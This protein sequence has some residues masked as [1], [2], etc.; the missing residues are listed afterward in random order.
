MA[1]LF[2]TSI[3]ASVSVLNLLTATTTFTPNFLAFSMCFCRLQHPFNTKSTFS[4]MYSFWSGLPADTGGPPPCIF[5]ART[6]ATMTAALGFKPLYRHLML[7]NFSIPMSA[8]KPASVTQNP[9]G[10]ISLRAIWSATT[11]L[12]PV[13]I[14]A[15]GPACT[16]TGVLSTVCI[17]VG[18]MASFINTV[19]APPQPRSS[20]VTGSPCREYPTTI[21]PS[22]SRRS[23][24]SFAN[25][26]TAI[27]SDA[28][29][30]S[31]PV[32]RSCWIRSPSFSFFDFT[33][34]FGPCPTVI[35]RKCR[36]HVSKTRCHVIVSGSRSSLAKLDFSSGV[37]SSGERPS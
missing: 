7:K 36:S 4:S 15:N 20:A 27:T 28:T 25:A 37:N 17:S 22:F 19:N 12:F 32:L 34:S 10:P 1:A 21:A 30:I 5:N 9:S 6:V 11:E 24:R 33:V 31:N 29:V 3:S 18:I 2:T 23:F 26:N 14:L 16:R 8:P 13:A 35:L